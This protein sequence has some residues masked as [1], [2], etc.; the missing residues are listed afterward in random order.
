MIDHSSLD[1]K[2]IRKIIERRIERDFNIWSDPETQV[3]TFFSVR[4]VQEGY[5]IPETMNI[6]MVEYETFFRQQ[7]LE[8]ILNEKK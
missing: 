7:K 3:E 8:R 4:I 6:T 5:Q 2:R 1:E